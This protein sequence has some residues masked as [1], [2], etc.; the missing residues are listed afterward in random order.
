M[1]NY[2]PNS[3]VAAGKA[4][5]LSGLAKAEIKR[6]LDAGSHCQPEAGNKL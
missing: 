5:Y 1:N 4:K 6:S 3:R 2:P